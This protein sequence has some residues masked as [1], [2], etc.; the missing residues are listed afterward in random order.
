MAEIVNF[1]KARKARD[2]AAAKTQAAENRAA[3]GRPKA[4]TQQSLLE[5]LA[6]DRALDGHRRDRAPEASDDD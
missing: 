5:R 6:R 4:E 1:N 2:K 3:H